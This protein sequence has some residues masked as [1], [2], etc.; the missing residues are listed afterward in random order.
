MLVRQIRYAAPAPA[1]PKWWRL[2]RRTD[3]GN[4]GYYVDGHDSDAIRI[5]SDTQMGDLAN[6]A[7][8]LAFSLLPGTTDWYLYLYP[9]QG[10][11]SVNPTA[12]DQ[13]LYYVSLQTPLS[14]LFGTQDLFTLSGLSNNEPGD[15]YGN[16]FTKHWNG[17]GLEIVHQ[18][19]GDSL[20]YSSTLLLSGTVDSQQ[21]FQ[22]VDFQSQLFPGIRTSDA[23]PTSATEGFSFSNFGVIYNGTESLVY[24]RQEDD[25]YRLSNTANNQIHPSLGSAFSFAFLSGSSNETGPIVERFNSEIWKS[26]RLGELNGLLTK[27]QLDISVTGQ[28]VLALKPYPSVGSY[29]TADLIFYP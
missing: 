1:I 14:R 13:G 27:A 18:V 16:V 20:R 15:N 11:F 7:T 6:G 2:L 26:E 3:A 4:E 28:E 10:F 25:A 19:F 24:R 5:T 22:N 12:I 21:L 8:T 9:R 29:S 17:G 23:F